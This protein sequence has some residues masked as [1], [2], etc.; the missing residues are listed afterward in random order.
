MGRDVPVKAAILGLS[1]L[2]GGCAWHG[3]KDAQVWPELTAGPDVVTLDKAAYTLVAVQNK[4]VERLADGRT[5]VR[6]ELANLSA[7]DLPIQVQ[8]LF[9]DAGGT[10]LDDATPFEMIVL[11]GNGSKLYKATS[12]KPG[13][14][15]YTVQ[16][17][18]P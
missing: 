11:P 13:A 4:K 7:K 18:T 9:R 3:P 10:L 17:K 16:I 8:T 2:L 5:E 6:L 15:T 12:L 14:A 1:L